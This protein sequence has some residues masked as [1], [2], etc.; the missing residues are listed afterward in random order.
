MTERKEEQAAAWG[1]GGPPVPGAA[2]LRGD[3]RQGAALP[4]GLQNLPGQALR[5]KS[6]NSGAFV[7]SA[8]VSGLCAVKN[9]GDVF[10]KHQVPSFDHASDRSLH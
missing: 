7:E 3:S 2:A 6:G 10:E 1:L 8:T 4:Q 5:I 9:T